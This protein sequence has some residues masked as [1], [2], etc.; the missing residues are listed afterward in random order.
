MWGAGRDRED[1][2]IVF[3]RSVPPGYEGGV[4]PSSFVSCSRWRL[5][6][7]ATFLLVSLLFAMD[8]AEADVA[9]SV[10][11]A[12]APQLSNAPTVTL[13][14]SRVFADGVA[15]A[16]GSAV[17]PQNW[18]QPTFDERRAGWIAAK[19]LVVPQPTAA[20]S[21]TPSPLP[22]SVTS[23]P[24]GAGGSL[25]WRVRFDVS[26]LSAVKVLE[27]N[28]LYQDGVVAYLNGVE[29][30]RRNVPAASV[31]ARVDPSV[32][33]RPAVAHGSEPERIFL[34]VD[35]APW[36]LRAQDNVLAVRVASATTRAANDT[37]A[38][39]GQVGVA[40]FSNVRIVRGPYLVAPNDHGLSVA[41]ET[42]QPSRGTVSVAPVDA[43]AGSAGLRVLKSDVPGLRHVVR[44]SGL[45][46]GRRYRYVVDASSVDVPPVRVRSP[47]AAFETAPA[48][49]GPAR[50]IVYGDMRAPGHAAHA[51]VVAGI[52]R[53]RPALV[54]NTGDLVA[55]GSEESAWQRYFE[56]TAPLGAIAPVVPALGNHEAYI[57]GAAKSWSLFG[58]S[59]ASPAPGTGFTSLDWGGIHIVVLDTNNMDSAQ[60]EWLTKD[61]AS[62]KK[63]RP[64]AIFAIC[65]EGPWAHGAHGGS[66]MMEREVAPLLVAGGVDVLFA[67]HDHIYERGVGSVGGRA[68][69]P[70]VIAGGGGAPLYNPSCETP[71]AVADKTVVKP[72]STLPTCPTSV[73]IIKKAYHYIVV[74]VDAGTIRLCPRAPDGSEIEPCVA[75]KSGANLTRR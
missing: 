7:G 31:D 40:V 6:S 55:V 24:V 59:S 5:V 12:L 30:A 28:I 65:H 41:W 62:A 39:T 36:R 9:V 74:E 38:P 27:L 15:G 48:K 75:L 60:K 3:A 8:P 33:A 67:G 64:R 37:N 25:Y 72:A 10:E 35:G 4:K 22:S 58:L 23:L 1:R 19:G 63:H 44:V 54:L 61:L 57:K 21:A 71:T 69:L 11:K 46:P 17:L 34:P 73:G 2:S 32:G 50:L 45:N 53:E 68:V 43:A 16:G 70:Y 29:V 52:L 66:R 49:Q 26:A 47:E 14:S 20:V 51:Q 18:N 42:D 56:I 13:R